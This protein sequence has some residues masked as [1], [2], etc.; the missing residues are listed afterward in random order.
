MARLRHIILAAVLSL[1]L[2][3][4]SRAQETTGEG[5]KYI[6]LPREYR[7]LYDEL[8]EKLDHLGKGIR[9]QW[10]GKKAGTAF[11]VE[12]LVANSN[13][14]EV[15]LTDRVFEATILTLDRLKDLGVRSVALSIQYPILTPSYPRSSEYRDFY[16]RVARQIRS[17]GYVLVVEMGTTFREPEFSKMRVDYG[18][19]TMERF[20][21]QLRQMAERI[22]G[23]LGPDYFTILNEPDTQT[24]NTGLNFSVSNYAATIRHV[25]EGL[26]HPG[27]RLGAGAGTWSPMAYFA[28]LVRIPQLDYIDL[29]IYPIQRD[30]ILDRVTEVTGL[31]RKQEKGVSIGEAWLYKVSRR[32]LGRISPVKAFARDV[33]SFW[34]PLDTQFL[35][36]IVNLSH[37]IDAEF[38]SFFWMKYL[39][40]YIDYNANTRALRPQRLINA[41][42]SLAGRQ[43]LDGQLNQTG[44]RLKMLIAPDQ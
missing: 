39:Y 36:V 41:V 24:T 9:S 43:I 7:A 35:E 14:G 37:H 19:L 1:G 38:C 31:A 22:V 30:F 13:R 11:G 12:L 23:D 6:S 26:Q 42:D 15:L 34:Q 29:H 10:N 2:M 21:G 33:Y 44:E 4:C 20:N 17:R 32:E 27:V 40:G 5:V 25:V 3:S 16:K 18:G 8:A 28:A